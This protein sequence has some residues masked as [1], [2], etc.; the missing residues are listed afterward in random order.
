MFGFKFKPCNLIEK[1]YS[2]HV[3]IISAP[4]P[5]VFCYFLLFF[6]I[7]FFEKRFQPCGDNLCPPS[8]SDSHCHSNQRQRRVHGPLI[9]ISLP[10][11]ATSRFYLKLLLYWNEISWRIPIISVWSGLV[12]SLFMNREFTVANTLLLL[13]P[14]Q[15]RRMVM[16]I[17]LPRLQK[18][19][20]SQISAV[21]SAHQTSKQRKE[22]FS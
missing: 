3:E 1:N 9:K 6:V 13:I 4:G 10:S 20:V 7:F 17:H 5:Q 2:N 16:M 15:Y 22:L 14:A 8:P 11:T 19:C 12:W 18:M 21:H